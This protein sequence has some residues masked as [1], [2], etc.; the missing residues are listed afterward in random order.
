[1]VIFPSPQKKSHL[2]VVLA[3]IEVACPLP[4]LWHC[5]VWTPAKDM[6]ECGELEENPGIRQVMP[7][8]HLL[9]HWGRGPAAAKGNS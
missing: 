2:G 8:K 5:F 3:L 9:V 4:G 1:M 7:G 6:L